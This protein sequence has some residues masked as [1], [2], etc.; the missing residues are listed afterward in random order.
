[1]NKKIFIIS[2]IF[3][4]IDQITKGIIDT[5]LTLNKSIIVIKNFFYLTNVHNKGAAWG[6]FD[7]KIYLLI[8]VSVIALV[9]VYNFLCT[10]KENKRNNIA[11][12][13]LLGGIIGNLIDRIFIGYVRDFIDVYI[14]NYNFPVFNISDSC[15]VIGTVLLIYAIIKGEDKK[16]GIRGKKRRKA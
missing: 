7:D 16:S 3:I 4:L 1:M 14:G 9:I 5:Y 13:I 15:I 6:I 8:G 12:G 11:F 10:F 2:C